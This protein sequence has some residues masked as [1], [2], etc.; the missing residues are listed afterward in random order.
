MNP[1]ALTPDPEYQARQD[2][3]HLNLLSIFYY[4]AA[5]LL[6]LG[7]LIFLFHIF[8][9]LMFVTGSAGT[10]TTITATPGTFPGAPPFSP[11]PTNGPPPAAFGWLFVA[12]GTGALLLFETFAVVTFM[13]G[14]SLANREKKTLIQVV[15]ALLC[16]NVPLGTAL[17]VF[18]LIVLNR[19]SV[20]ALFDAPR[21][22]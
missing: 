10:S 12:I 18:T 11:P 21:S 6:G 2:A 13:A 14:R 4:I 16:L 9:G 22:S 15:A 5:A 8:M 19:P 1:V 20:A 17:G 3:E 7:G